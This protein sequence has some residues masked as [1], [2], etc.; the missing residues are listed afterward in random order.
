MAN[1]VEL[2]VGRDGAIL[3]DVTSGLF[4][5]GSTLGSDKA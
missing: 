3:E 1:G 2:K 5:L 4:T